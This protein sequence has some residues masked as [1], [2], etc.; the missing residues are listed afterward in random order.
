MN[1]AVTFSDVE[2]DLALFH[3][4]DIADRCLMRFMLWG[5][6]ARSM[7][8]KGLP[9][10]DGIYLA[11]RKADLPEFVLSTL[12][13]LAKGSDI[14]YSIKDFKETDNSFSWTYHNVPITIKVVHRDYKFLHNLDF[15]WYK[16]EE[17]RIPNPFEGYWKTRSLVK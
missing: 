11:V 3:A 12:R 16:A 9:E 17:Y 2:L 8:D 7:V 15:I 1:G 5:N 10:G 13:T 14:N 6:T 4:V